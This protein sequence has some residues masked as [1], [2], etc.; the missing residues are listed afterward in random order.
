MN[1]RGFITSIYLYAIVAVVIA[2]M[3]W[4]LYQ[5]I[6]QVGE[7]E[8]TIAVQQKAIEES[9]KL[10]RDAETAIATRDA[11]IAATRTEI[12]RYRSKLK[13]LEAVNAE[14]AAWSNTP[15]PAAIHGILCELTGRGSACVPAT[16]PDAKP[17][18]A[19][20]ERENERRPFAMVN[21]SG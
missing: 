10:R 16:N 1:Q 6:K 5:K 3:G 17:P 19:G 12:N 2:G 4:F 20:M 13:A 9:E 15:L 11:K 8:T 7:L 21:G 18:V 14:L